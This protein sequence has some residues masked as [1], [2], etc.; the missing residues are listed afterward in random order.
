MLADEPSG[1]LDTGTSLKLH[2][3]LFS[4]RETRR[5]SL[6]VVTHNADLAGRADQVLVLEQGR[7][8]PATR[9]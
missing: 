1:N 3:L 6:V 5:V 8:L 2:D 7:L 4:L 9:V